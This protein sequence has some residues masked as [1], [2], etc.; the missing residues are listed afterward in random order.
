VKVPEHAV[1][2]YNEW[3][4]SQ[5]SDGYK[6]RNLEIADGWKHLAPFFTYIVH[7]PF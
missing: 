6:S 3:K 5:V 2:G 7:D 4:I 1:G